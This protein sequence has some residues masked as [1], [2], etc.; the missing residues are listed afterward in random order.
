MKEIKVCEENLNYLYTKKDF[1]FSIWVQ[2]NNPGLAVQWA[3]HSYSQKRQVDVQMLGNEVETVFCIASA[4][5]SLGILFPETDNTPWKGG[6]KLE[7][8]GQ[9]FHHWDFWRKAERSSFKTSERRWWEGKIYEMISIVEK[10][11]N[12]LMSLFYV[13]E[14]GGKEIIKMRSFTFEIIEWNIFSYNA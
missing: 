9:H 1:T 3:L 7:K 2:E 8:S 4:T 11:D 13:P 14:A 10:R 5:H 6:T 12:F